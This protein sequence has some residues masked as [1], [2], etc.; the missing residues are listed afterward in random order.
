MG[1]SKR[2]TGFLI[3]LREIIVEGIVG[4]VWTVIK[5]V[6]QS[7]RLEWGEEGQ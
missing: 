4:T 7:I 6:A 3:V 5:A 1:T 2:H